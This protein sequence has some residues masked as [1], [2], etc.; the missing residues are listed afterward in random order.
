MEFEPVIGLEVHVQL[1][2]QSKIFCDCPTAFGAPPNTHTCP[3]CLGMPGVLPVL[4]RQVVDYALRMA[5][6]LS[7][8]VSPES[9]FARKNYFYP[10]LPKGYQISQFDRPLAENGSLEIVLEDGT[11]RTI[12]ITRIHLEDDAGKNLHGE[13]PE[14]AGHS[15]V[16]LNR[17]GVPLIEIVSEPDLRTPEEAAAYMRQVR[18][19]V[20][21]LGISDGN[22]Q[23]GSLRCDANVSVRPVGRAEFGV[24]AEL[25]NM[26]SFKFVAKALEYEIERQV[27]TLRTGGAIVQETRLW[28][29]AEQITRSMR[30]KEEAHDY[31][32]FPEPDLVP[33][34][35]DEA[36]LARVQSEMPELP[37]AK[38]D[39]FVERYELSADDAATLTE[40][41]AL[42]EYFEA[43]AADVP[44]PRKAA[45]WI[46]S[47]LL[48][49]W[50]ADADEPIPV[51]ATNMA[52]MLTLV[53]DGTISGKM[54]K[55]V[56]D[57]MWSTGGAP[58]A[59]V[60]AK[61]MVQISDRSQIEALLREIVETNPAQVEQFRAGKEKVLGFFVGQ[62]MKAT[63]GQANPQI[64]NEVL[65]ELLS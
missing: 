38:R 5:L 42:A 33:L 39:R 2:T 37:G 9:I 31:R 36:W 28:S 62:A 47:E 34:V 44:D 53:E 59:I 48:R 8:T 63:K 65:R 64:V 54:A 61:G 56:F 32:Y 7:C 29:E 3:V 45:N 50:N 40:S 15:L 52:R 57:E 19:I 22:M 43:V 12:G 4:N 60:E 20:R 10:D 41:L 6:A 23:E 18:R 27:E 11:R 55:T 51:S 24:K 30:G 14:D 25:K 58:D 46:L 35:V 26:N 17:T 13:S 1:R 21:Y 49:R 16:D